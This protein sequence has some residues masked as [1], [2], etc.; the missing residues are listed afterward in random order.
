MHLIAD[1][2]PPT[3]QER[4]EDWGGQARQQGPAPGGGGHAARQRNANLA[5]RSNL[6]ESRKTDQL[7]LIIVV[8]S[9]EN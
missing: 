3:V 1:Q 7:E 9:Q 8:F 5:K 6:V 4:G 2:Q